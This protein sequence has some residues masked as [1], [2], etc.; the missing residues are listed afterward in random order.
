MAGDSFFDPEREFRRILDVD[1]PC[2]LHLRHQPGEKSAGIDLKLSM[3]KGKDALPGIATCQPE[4]YSPGG[5]D[6]LSTNFQK[7]E[8]EL[9]NLHC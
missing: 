4:A 9:L 2:D 3:R 1:L 6:Y 8:P 5:L 7:S